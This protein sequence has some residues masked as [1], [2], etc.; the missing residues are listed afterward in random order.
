MTVEIQKTSKH[1][2]KILLD[3]P[4]RLNA[5]DHDHLSQYIDALT[6]ADDDNQVRAVV[7]AARGPA[8]CAGLDLKDAGDP[9]LSEGVGRVQWTM[10]FQRHFAE[11][12]AKMREIRP[13]IVA[14][15]QGA[16]T[17]AGFALALGADIRT[18]GPAGRFSVANVRIGLSG[19]DIGMSYHLPRIV[20]MN[21]AANLMLTGRMMDSAEAART[22]LT[23]SVS[24][25]PEAE[26]D[27][28]AFDIAANSPFGTWMTKEVMWLNADATGLRQA[29]ALEDRTQV[30]ASFTAD[31]E[32]GVLAFLQKRDPVFEDQ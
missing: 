6:Q 14:A 8:F 17:G 7:L 32:E 2:T 21:C 29:M 19:C 15:V 25:D 27:Q 5:L 28:L 1:T 24:D 20:G 18:I 9:P 4:E 23:N 11:A 31:N 22:G 12:I 16:A 26:A 10:R 3:R 13:P 30:V